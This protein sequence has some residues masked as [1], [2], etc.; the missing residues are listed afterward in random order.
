MNYPS[1]AI[2]L[3]LANML[4]DELME[5]GLSDEYVKAPILLKTRLVADVLFMFGVSAR[6]VVMTSE[7]GHIGTS[8]LR[9]VRMNMHTI[10]DS[11]DSILGDWDATFQVV[12]RDN[13]E[14]FNQGRVSRGCQ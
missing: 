12:E 4:T 11:M 6:T 3:H 5:L 13:V 14:L 1:E 9:Y 10:H 2:S 8:V 7:F